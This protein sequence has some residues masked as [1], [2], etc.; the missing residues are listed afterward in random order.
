MQASYRVNV[1]ELDVG[2]VNSLK[3][4]FKNKKIN[5]FIEDVQEPS[6]KGEDEQMTKYIQSVQ[7]QTDKEK[8]KERLNDY[9]KNGLENCSSFDDTWKKIEKQIQEQHIKA[10]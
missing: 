8:V 1:N 4:I 3:E 6:L 7:F 9:K 2:F 10:V 5:I